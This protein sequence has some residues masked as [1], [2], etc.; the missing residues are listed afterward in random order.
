MSRDLVVAEARRQFSEGAHYIKR[1][2]GHRFNAQG[3]RVDDVVPGRE[4]AVQFVLTGG[5]SSG[6]P[7]YVRFAAKSEHNGRRVCAGRC[8]LV[9]QNTPQAGDP[10]NPTHLASPQQ[11]FWRRPR[12][13]ANATE[14]VL[15]ECCIGKRH[16]DCIGFVNWCFWKAIS[17]P[18]AP[19]FTGIP[20]WKSQLTEPIDRFAVPLLLLPGDILFSSTSAEESSTGLTHIGIVV[21]S[22]EVAHAA[23]HHLGVQITPINASGVLG[24]GI[25][26]ERMAGRPKVFR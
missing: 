5:G 21:S 15:G 10:A 8:H 24:G 14:R 1:G 23:G 16:F 25:V 26:W 20:L 19:G 18:R 13:Y 4:A 17:S 22:T 11:H 12:N 3:Q 2:Y 7:D 9:P 6:V